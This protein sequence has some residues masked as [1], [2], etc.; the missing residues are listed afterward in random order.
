MLPVELA[1]DGNDCLFVADRNA[2]AVRKISIAT[3]A[4]T[5]VVGEIGKSGI[6]LGPLPARLTEPSGLAFVPPDRLFI[7][8]SRENAVLM[9][10]F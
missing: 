4:V 6:V 1:H 3:R 5:T 10:Q 8:D 9:A 2:H 7:V